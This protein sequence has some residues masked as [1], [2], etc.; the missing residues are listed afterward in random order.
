MNNIKEPH[1]KLELEFKK[2]YKIILK[3]SSLICTSCKN[4]KFDD[5]ILLT[6]IKGNTPLIVVN[7]I[8]GNQQRLITNLKL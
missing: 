6:D 1:E 4:T 7:C 8:C 3:A 5:V 2:H